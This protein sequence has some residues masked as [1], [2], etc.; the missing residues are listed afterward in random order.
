M[1]GIGKQL[2]NKFQKKK[3]LL[4]LTGSLFAVGGIEKCNRNLLDAVLGIGYFMRVISR[5]DTEK[6]YKNLPV[7]SFGHH[8]VI[9]IRKIA[10]ASRTFL[11]AIFYNPDIIICGHINFSPL[12][13]IIS[14]FFGKRY[15][16]LTHG[17]DVWDITSKTK[18]KGLKEAYLITSVSNFT[19]DKIIEQIPEVKSKV[20]LLPNTIDGTFF[21]PK[22]KPA[23]LLKRHNL[24]EDDKIILTIARLSKSEKY[25]GYDKVIEVLPRVIKEVPSVKYIIGGTGD[26]VRRVKELVRIKGLE[27]HV[28]LAGFIPEEEMVDHYNLCDVFVMP[29]KKEG[30]GIVFLEALACGKP[31]IAGNK[32][33]SVDALLN[34][35]LGILVDPDNISEIAEAIVKALKGQIDKKFLDR[36]YLRERVIEEYGA[37]R[38]KERVGEILNEKI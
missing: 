26:D 3:K 17:I 28:I 10:F 19:K 13:Y 7:I 34:G 30:F 27:G 21:H 36:K 24:R 22:P 31:V 37:D 33:G 35:E 15:I 29:S 9:I 6:E 23:Y 20:Y 38:F 12:C 18:I 8:K 11:E 32:D 4:F 25:K 16:V 2:D 1:C 14:K 5:N